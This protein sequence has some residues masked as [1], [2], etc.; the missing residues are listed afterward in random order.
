MRYLILNQNRDEIRATGG[1]PGSVVFVEI[2]RGRITQKAS[3]DIYL[4][5]W[6]LY[7]FQ[8]TPPPGIRELTT[9]YGLR[10]ANYDPILK[11]NIEVMSQFHERSG[12]ESLDAI[13]TIHQG[14]IEDLLGVIGPV[15]FPEISTQITP[16]NFSLIISS[17]VEAKFGK[18]ESAKDILFVFE[19]HLTEKLQS[20]LSKLPE[21]V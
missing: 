19:K 6:K 7:P 14:L 9:N 11:N 20:S 13:I 4:Y 2:D 18:N 8:V 21:V 15:D 12:Y 16:D 3:R 1:F 5:D 17:I 10:D